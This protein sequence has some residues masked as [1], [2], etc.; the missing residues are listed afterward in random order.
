VILPHEPRIPRMEPAPPGSS[1]KTIGTAAGMVPR[2][3]ATT[4]IPYF[5]RRLSVLPLDGWFAR[6][7]WC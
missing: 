3:H 1:H 6:C 5:H 4:R 7:A 2:P